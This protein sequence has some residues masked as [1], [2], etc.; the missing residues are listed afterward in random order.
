MHTFV[1][2]LTVVVSFPCE[3]VAPFLKRWLLPQIDVIQRFRIGSDYI[4]TMLMLKRPFRC[5]PA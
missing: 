1:N 2:D 4:M 5:I 3:R